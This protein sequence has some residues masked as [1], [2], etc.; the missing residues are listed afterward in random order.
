[1]S[2]QLKIHDI[3]KCYRLGKGEFRV[4]GIRY[5]GSKDE[6]VRLQSLDD[7]SVCQWV[8]SVHCNTNY[9]LRNRINTRH[10]EVAANT[11]KVGI[12]PEQAAAIVVNSAKVGITPD[13]ANDIVLA[14]THRNTTTGNPHQVTKTEVGLGNKILNKKSK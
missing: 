6:E 9:T 14:N 7:A 13:Q 8:Y 10:T 3:V 1:M 2:I 5:A 12:T 4:I 11:A